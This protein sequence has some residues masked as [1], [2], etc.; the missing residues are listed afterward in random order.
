L[1]KVSEGNS[2]PKMIKTLP[3][4]DKVK[5]MSCGREHSAFIL[6]EEGQG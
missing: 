4:N 6:S 1:K 3:N 2:N 5:S